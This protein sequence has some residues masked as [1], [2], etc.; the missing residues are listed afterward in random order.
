L[1]K[2]FGT[3]EVLSRYYFPG[4]PFPENEIEQYEL[5]AEIEYLEERLAIN[6]AYA[7]AMAFNG[8]K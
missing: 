6:Q 7:I 2:G 5:L 4:Y 8:K 1:K 3:L